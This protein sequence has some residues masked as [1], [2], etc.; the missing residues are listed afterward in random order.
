MCVPSSID[1]GRE[2]ASPGEIVVVTGQD[3]F[4]GCNDIG[5][6]G[7]TPQMEPEQGIRIEFQQ[8]S[9][10]WTLTTV[11]AEADYSFEEPVEIPSEAVKGAA[12]VVTHGDDGPV[13]L[14]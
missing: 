8:G 11:D 7:P 5:G 13:E 9:R 4:R 2:G 12:K 10:T 1:V 3:F 6:T 14:E